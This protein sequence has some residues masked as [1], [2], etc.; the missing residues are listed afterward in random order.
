MPSRRV[1]KG[2]LQETEDEFRSWI[3]G[4][5]DLFGWMYFHALPAL[6]LDGRVRTT[7][8]GDDGFPDVCVAKDG[9]ILLFECK[10]SDPDSKPTIGQVAWTT[11][12]GQYGFIVRPADR[13]MIERLLR[14][15][16]PK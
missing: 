7:F 13:P 12:A 2:R 1:V 11:A 10:T 16:G 15:G 6:R 5:A 4:A 3:K 9:V 8:E 14:D